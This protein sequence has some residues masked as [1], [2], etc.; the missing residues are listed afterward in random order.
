[1]ED[2]RDSVP[3]EELSSNLHIEEEQALHLL[4]VETET[5]S[6]ALLN[7]SETI[8]DLEPDACDPELALTRS[9]TLSSHVAATCHQADDDSSVVH[10]P[11]SGLIQQLVIASILDDI[12]KELSDDGD[13]DDDDETDTD[14]DGVSLNP[15]N[16]QNSS[17]SRPLF[18]QSLPSP[19]VKTTANLVVSRPKPLKQRIPAAA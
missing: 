7:E 5:S 9:P 3:S 6:R 12:E 2:L 15:T 16:S 19:M 18:T 11:T 8:V 4:A 13:D 17:H 1:M 10:I 14:S